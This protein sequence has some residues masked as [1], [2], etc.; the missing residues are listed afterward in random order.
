[1]LK[2]YNYLLNSGIATFNEHNIP[3]YEH[4]RG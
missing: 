2:L 3:S 4:N 1:M